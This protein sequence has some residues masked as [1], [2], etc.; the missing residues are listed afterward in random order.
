MFALECSFIQYVFVIVSVACMLL[1]CVCCWYATGNRMR[2]VD[3]IDMKVSIHRYRIYNRHLYILSGIYKCPFCIHNHVQV[4]VVGTCMASSNVKTKDHAL[5][6]IW[7]TQMILVAASSLFLPLPV[8]PA[9]LPVCLPALFVCLFVCPL[10]LSSCLHPSFHPSTHT[11]I[12]L[13]YMLTR[14]P[15]SFILHIHS[16]RSFIRGVG[17]HVSYANT[18]CSITVLRSHTVLYHHSTPA[19]RLFLWLLILI[20]WASL[21]RLLIQL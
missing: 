17:A 19:S 2:G 11:H 10:L 3:T 1:F 7:H 15:F 18:L 21:S 6:Y 8:L 12:Y 13:T 20:L 5:K 14:S 4:P 9:Y 16:S